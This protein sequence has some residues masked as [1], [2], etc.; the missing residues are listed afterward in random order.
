MSTNVNQQTM[1]EALFRTLGADESKA[2]QNNYQGKLTR[3]LAVNGIEEFI[4]RNY[5]PDGD[6]R[7]FVTVSGKMTNGALVSSLHI[8]RDPAAP[9]RREDVT[10]Y[11]GSG[12]YINLNPPKAD[13]PVNIGNSKQ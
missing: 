5:V 1:M 13:T 4:Y 2:W 11:G 12:D 10:H 7:Y 3:L 9:Q 6:I 8:Q